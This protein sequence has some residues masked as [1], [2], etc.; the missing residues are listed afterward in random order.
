MLNHSLLAPT[1]RVTLD[2]ESLVITFYLKG[3]VGVAHAVISEILTGRFSRQLLLAAR[4]KR[5]VSCPLHILHRDEADQ[6]LTNCETNRLAHKTLC[7][8]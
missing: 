8:L 6:R 1:R 2:F 5:S 3:F 4:A 7:G